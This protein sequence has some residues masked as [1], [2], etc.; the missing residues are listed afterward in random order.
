MPLSWVKRKDFGD[1][2]LKCRRTL[3]NK[4]KRVEPETIL[5]WIQNKH[6]EY[7]PAYR[8]FLELRDK[9]LISLLYLMCGR[10][11]EVLRLKREQFKEQKNFLIVTEFKVVKNKVNPI[12][13]DWALPK[14]GKLAPFTHIILEY[15][16]KL[17][18]KRNQLFLIKRSRAWQI[19]NEITGKWNHWFRAM[20]EAFYMKNVFKEP[21]K[22]AS[23]LRLRRSDTLIEYVPFEWKDYE[24]QLSA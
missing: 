21:V 19:V 3:A 5:E 6:W 2:K 12:R 13:D 11:S 8:D 7:S 10:I 15:L 22:C 4:G 17:P 20:G 9:A 16:E 18:E 23:A 24:K 14:Q 1:G